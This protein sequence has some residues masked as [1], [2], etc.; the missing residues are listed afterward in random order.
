VV[1]PARTESIELA[2]AQPNPFAGRTSLRFRLP[3][4]AHVRLS[5]VDVSGRRVAQ[6]I[7][8]LLPAGSHT[9]TFDA[10][11]LPSG[12]YHCM[13]ETDGAVTVRPVVHLK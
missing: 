13:L 3:A 11:N 7:D 6:L 1:P 10:T 4:E 8:G 5:V 12:V 9:A 2:P